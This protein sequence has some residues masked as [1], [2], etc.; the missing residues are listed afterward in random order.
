MEV[1]IG[2]GSNRGERREN[3]EKAIQYLRQDW[4]MHI[5]KQSSIIETE[6]CGGPPQDKYLN[7]VIKVTTCV[8]PKVLLVQLQAV[9]KKMGRVRTIKNGPRIIDLDI[10]L[11]GQEC[12][13]EGELIIP[14]LRMLG[15]DFVMKPLLEIEP[16][17]LTSNK[18]LKNKTFS[19]I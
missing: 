5:E 8:V 11:Y 19:R 2:L 9:E 3:I 17:I 13:D 16:D 4:G 15:R 6:P 7:A 12:I 14:H 1:F 18:A 10:L